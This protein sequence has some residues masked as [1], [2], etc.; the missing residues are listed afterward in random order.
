MNEQYKKFIVGLTL[1][2]AL[3]GAMLFG[4]ISAFALTPSEGSFF[5]DNYAKI[6]HMVGLLAGIRDAFDKYDENDGVGFDPPEYGRMIDEKLNTVEDALSRIGLLMGKT[7]DPKSVERKK[8]SLTSDDY[9][10]LLA[11]ENKLLAIAIANIGLVQKYLDSYISSHPDT[12][13]GLQSILQNVKDLSHDLQAKKAAKDKFEEETYGIGKP[14]QPPVKTPTTGGGTGGGTLG[15]QPPKAPSAPA[16]PDTSF[17]QKV[18]NAVGLG[19]A[20]ATPSTPSQVSA[21]NVRVQF[22]PTQINQLLT[23]E[24]TA[25]RDVF[26]KTQPTSVAGFSYTP[27]LKPSSGE[28]CLTAQSSGGAITASG[29]FYAQKSS[30]KEI[31]V[32]AS[33]QTTNTATGEICVSTGFLSGI[34]VTD[35]ASLF[36]RFSVGQKVSATTRGVPSADLAAALKTT[37]DL[38]TRVSAL[39]A[40]A[41]KFVAESR[42]IFAQ[43]NAGQKTDALA[44]AKFIQATANPNG[45]LTRAHAWLL[46]E[47]TFIADT[48]TE[49]ASPASHTSDMQTLTQHMSIVAGAIDE[50]SVSKLDVMSALEDRLRALAGILSALAASDNLSAQDKANIEVMAGEIIA[51][52]KRV[53][54]TVPDAQLYDTLNHGAALEANNKALKQ[55]YK[56]L[57]DRR[58]YIQQLAKKAQSVSPSF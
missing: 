26:Y 13:S 8:E 32:P 52:Y 28:F 50:Q 38:I 2:V 16:V 34:D 44:N 9:K 18:L 21:T 54:E 25:T 55:L 51:F 49:L 10:A 20:P 23:R 48:K 30:G 56:L 39:A 5:T 24:Q 41:D 31:A 42:A 7:S 29:I 57:L 6:S 11:D 46:R 43:L 22:S 58:D 1:G 12:S 19:S 35:L 36:W 33:Y 53:V 27:A 4:P 37:N 40:D 17:F 14:P 45:F 3:L 47:K 15:G